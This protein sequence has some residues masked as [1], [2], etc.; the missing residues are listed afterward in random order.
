MKFIEF[1]AYYHGKI[2]VGLVKNYII[3][4]YMAYIR[5]DTH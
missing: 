5:K 4:G 1:L 3:T 2:S